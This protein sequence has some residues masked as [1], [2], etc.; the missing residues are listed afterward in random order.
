MNAYDLYTFYVEPADLKGQ[1]HRVKI[2]A[3][4]VKETFNPRT[5]QKEKQIVLRFAGRQK[6]LG[7]NKTRAGQM[8]EITGTPEFEK[9]I[10]IEVLIKPGKQ[11]GKD[12]VVIEAAAPA[13]AQTQRPAS[14]NQPQPI[15]ASRLEEI[16]KQ[17][18][19]DS[20]VAFSDLWKAA[21]LD[22][23]QVQDILRECGGDYDAAFEKIAEQYTQVI[24]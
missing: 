13:Q 23:A 5:K 24:G 7:L 16:R 17:A 1:A 4:D 20:L 10:G 9:W 19:T 3:A 6:V 2:A 12:T 8:I 22:S 11:S 14:H 18:K 15:T 21:G